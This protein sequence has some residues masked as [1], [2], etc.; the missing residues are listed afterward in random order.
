MKPPVERPA[1]VKKELKD[2]DMTVTEDDIQAE[3]DLAKARFETEVVPIIN[4]LDAIVASVPDQAAKQRLEEFSKGMKK[5][6]TKNDHSMVLSEILFVRF[7]TFVEDLARYKEKWPERITND[8]LKRKDDLAV[9]ER[10]IHNPHMLGWAL[11]LNWRNQALKK[12]G[13]EKGF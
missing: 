12:K 13:E 8:L 1:V 4:Q 5:I 7:K 3:K 9:L 2:M 6:Y 10:P 11:S